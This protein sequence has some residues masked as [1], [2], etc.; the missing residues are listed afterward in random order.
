MKLEK[1]NLEDLVS[2]DYNPRT[3]SELEMSKLKKSLTE[4][5]YCDP[6]IVNDVNMH[7]VGGNQRYYAFKELGYT[8]IDV[9]FIHEPNMSKEKGLNIAL[10]KISGEWNYPKLNDLLTELSLDTDFDLGLTGF[11]N[12]NL[13]DFDNDLDSLDLGE[14][15]EDTMNQSFT[16]IVNSNNHE[17][18]EKLY[19]TLTLE[20]Y[21]CRIR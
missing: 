3:I 18:I 15:T 9:V 17:E 4:F 12:L 20:G 19:N 6:L 16:L 21:D 10:N 1:V 2:P 14:G 8:E 11:D 13:D 7:I 5:G